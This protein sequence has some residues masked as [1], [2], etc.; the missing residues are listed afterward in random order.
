MASRHRL[1]EVVR[2]YL[3]KIYVA[4]RRWIECLERSLVCTSAPHH[5]RTLT[6]A[7]SWSIPSHPAY[8]GTF[9]AEGVSG[10]GAGPRRAEVMAIG[11]LQ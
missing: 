6:R 7:L 1:S 4:K 8:T 3:G 2:L 5:G 9:G 10:R 11:S